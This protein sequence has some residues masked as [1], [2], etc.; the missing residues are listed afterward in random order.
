MINCRATELG[1]EA[2]MKRIPEIVRAAAALTLVAAC[3]GNVPDKGSA[4]S[5]LT[6]GEIEAV[7]TGNTL[8]RCGWRAFRRWEY[9]GTHRPDG[10]MT[11][12]IVWS[13]G[14]ES[15]DGTWAVEGDRYCRT[16]SNQWG[17]G[18]LGCFR[19]ARDG[20]HLRFSHESGA[21]GNAETYTYRIGV[22]CQ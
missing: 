5:D 18:A 15:A 10:T 2:R 17:G 12:T 3:A 6:G 16:W 14:G 22:P 21:A 11:G 19:V 13:G 8:H 20:G 4:G 7:L 1:M 9:T